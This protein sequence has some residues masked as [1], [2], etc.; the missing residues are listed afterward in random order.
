MNLDATSKGG[1]LGRNFSISGRLD[2]ELSHVLVDRSVFEATTGILRIGVG[3]QKRPP[4]SA[5]GIDTADIE[6]ALR[7]PAIL[8]PIFVTVGLRSQRDRVQRHEGVALEKHESTG[9]LVDKNPEG[10]CLV[11]SFFRVESRGVLLRRRGLCRGR[12]NPPTARWKEKE[13][14]EK[15][16][17]KGEVPVYG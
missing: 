6:G 17:Q 14:Q 5:A 3:E 8:H 4:K 11:K 2:D 10:T 16:N 13:S 9:G 7:C 1:L 15:R 12:R